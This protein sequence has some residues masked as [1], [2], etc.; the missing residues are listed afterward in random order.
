MQINRFVVPYFA[1]RLVRHRRDC[2]RMRE[3]IKVPSDRHD[4][5]I[6]RRPRVHR[7]IDL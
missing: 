4:R 2:L 3:P 7:R 5:Y 1:R 6:I